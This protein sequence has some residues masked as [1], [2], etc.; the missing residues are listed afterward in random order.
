MSTIYI[1]VQGA[2][3]RHSGE[4]VLVEKD[5]TVIK[6]F[7]LTWVERVVIAG[8][9]Q[10]TTQ[11]M[12]LFLKNKIQ[13]AFMS[14]YGNYRGR[15]TPGTHKNVYLRVEQYRRYQ[16]EAFRLTQAK[17]MIGGKLYNCQEFIQKHHRSHH[18]IN[19]AAEVA[20]IGRELDG[21]LG[22]TSIASLM[23]H[24]GTAAHHYFQ[25]LGKMVRREFAFDKRSKRPPTDP[26]NAMLSLGYTLLFNE[27]VSAAEAV[28]L[29]PYLGF[30]HEIDYGRPSLA[31]D[32]VEEFRYLIDSLVLAL[33]NRG[34]VHLSDFT[35]KEGEEGV[36]LSDTS[37]KAFYKSY[38][39]RMRDE[40]KHGGEKISYR[41]LFF[42]QAEQLARVIRTEGEGYSPFLM[43]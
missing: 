41:R 35:C 20:S 12:G 38:E 40:V 26:V 4:E 27:M 14:I 34:E 32:L 18:E 9:V 11:V 30:V 13:V 17:S 6:R 43:H 36:F 7:P 2:V 31:L 10:L 22:A 29:D 25:A 24:E 3:V 37:R 28:G 23:G 8:N 21:I 1:D 19:V 39:Q 42:N 33:I 5:A 16:D 15:L